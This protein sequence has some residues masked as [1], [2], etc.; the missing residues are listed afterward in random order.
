[1]LKIRTHLVLMAASILLPVVVFSAISLHLL[2]NGE[3]DA[4]LRGLHETARATALTVDREMA[5]FVTALELLARSPYLESGDLQAFY[6]QAS[7]ANKRA[8]SWTILLDENAQQLIN[9]ASPFGE[10]LPSPRPPGTV[11]KVMATQKPLA[12]NLMLGQVTK[13][14]ITV[15][16]VPVPA[17]GGKRYVLAQI[18]DIEFFKEAVF[19]PRLPRD[20]IVSLLDSD[21]RFIARNLRAKELVG[22]L[23]RAELLTLVQAQDEGLM[24]LK[25]LEGIESYTAFT[26]SDVTGWT[27]GVGAP[28][29]GI[30]ATAGNAAA[31]AALGLLLAI[32]IAMIVAVVLGRR[33][34]QSIA[35][36]TEAAV[37][38]GQG[39]VPKLKSSRVREI[40]QLHIALGDASRMLVDAYAARTQV[41]AEREGLLQ[42]EYEARVR[43]EAANQSKDQFLAM[44]GHELRNPLSAISGALAL[45]QRQG[46]GAAVA[47][48]YA[49]IARQSAHLSHLVDDLLDVSRMVGGKIQLHMQPIDLGQ[50]ALACIESLR[51]SGRTGDCEIKVTTEAVWVA[52]DT[53][54]LEQTINNLLINALKFTPPGGRVE[55]SVGARADEAVLT[56]KDSGVGIAPALLPHI[57]E[58]FVQGDTSL[59]RAQGGMGIGLALVR[60]LVNLH[61]GSVSAASAGP[62]QGSLFTLRLRRI[63]VPTALPEPALP[64]NMVATCWRILLIEDNEDARSMLR[65]LLDLDG[66]E[67]FEAATASDGLRLAGLQ[68]P[69]LAIVDIGLPDMS[70]Y[71]LAQRLRAGVA[72]QTMGLIAMTGYGQQEDR[73][74]ALAAGFDFHLTK[75]VDVEQ[76]LKVI[77]LCGHAA[78]LRHGGPAVLDACK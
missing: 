17:H 6:K 33:L 61:G 63:P 47:E 31:L 55:L 9:T 26:H 18:F 11:Q 27:I 49:V 53:T 67:V 58:L 54:R 45:S 1:M 25:T 32:G 3:R 60:Q 5:S 50:M 2:R 16:Y 4:A 65:Q 15:V 38:L 35:G 69:D 19:Q 42:N 59:D 24:R 57:F 56:V 13:K 7:Q 34:A 44:L 48:A 40:M 41:E 21:G 51:L 36:A 37:A 75:P 72:S 68:Q 77:D 30:E 76:L 8:T 46:H 29:G 39:A 22:K 66:H 23:A 52:G 43:A 78:R 74:N 10:L 12:S 71:E 64:A 20:W 70:G 14:L 28:V 73:K 62:D